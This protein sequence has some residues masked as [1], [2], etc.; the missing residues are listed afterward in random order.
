MCARRKRGKL[1]RPP[2]ASGSLGERLNHSTGLGSVPTVISILLSI[3]EENIVDC[4]RQL[5]G[6]KRSSFLIK[7][8]N[9][10]SEI[11]DKI[12]YSLCIY[13]DVDSRCCKLTWL[14]SQ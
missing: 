5:L 11:I 3:I 6:L 14:C 9:R 10:L 1:D 8:A 2:L 13:I 4:T 7:Y 12:N